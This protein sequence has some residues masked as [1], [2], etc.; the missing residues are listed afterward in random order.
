LACP[1]HL[2]QSNK[3]ITDYKTSSTATSPLAITTYNQVRQKPQLNKG[4]QAH[5]N[6]LIGYNITAENNIISV[7]VSSSDICERIGETMMIIRS[8]SDELEA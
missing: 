7:D 1:T 8:I 5:T 6:A 4:M 3:D 2:G